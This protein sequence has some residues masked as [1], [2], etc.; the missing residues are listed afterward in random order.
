MAPE[1]KLKEEKIFWDWKTALV[2]VS[3]YGILIIGIIKMSGLLIIFGFIMAFIS[4]LE[5]KKN[6]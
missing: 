5:G 4:E 3:S 2:K 6:D 1:K